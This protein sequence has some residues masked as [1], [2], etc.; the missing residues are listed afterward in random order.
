MQMEI[1]TY[2]SS[3]TQEGM[4]IWTRVCF[5]WPP[6]HFYSASH[7]SSPGLELLSTGAEKPSLLPN[8]G[9][10]LYIRF[11]KQLPTLEFSHTRKESYV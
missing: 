10:Q 5:N 3:S 7:T 11:Q 2:I 4:D 8:C 1:Y 9:W 6:P